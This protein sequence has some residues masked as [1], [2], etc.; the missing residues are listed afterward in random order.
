MSN[1][2]RKA[3]GDKIENEGEIRYLNQYSDNIVIALLEQSVCIQYTLKYCLNAYNLHVIDRE[4]HLF[5]LTSMY[6][7]LQLSVSQKARHRHKIYNR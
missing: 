5:F 3:V 6:Y 1:S 7:V 4:K 2:T